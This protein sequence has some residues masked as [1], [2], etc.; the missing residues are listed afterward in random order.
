MINYAVPVSPRAARLT[1]LPT[2]L[3]TF[4]LVVFSK[5]VLMQYTLRLPSAD[6]SLIAFLGVM[7]VSFALPAGTWFVLTRSARRRPAAWSIEQGRF[8]VPASPDVYGYQAIVACF[9]TSRSPSRAVRSTSPRSSW[10]SP[11]PTTATSRTPVS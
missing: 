5:F 10:P 4:G 11:P 2:A 6:L 3:L 9:W 7:V 1:A 8:V